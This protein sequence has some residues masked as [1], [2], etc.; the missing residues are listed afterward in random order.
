MFP[1]CHGVRYQGY[2]V[3]FGKINCW[4]GFMEIMQIN[5]HVCERLLA[6]VN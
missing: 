5:F 3:T 6:K 4:Q 2:G 1:G